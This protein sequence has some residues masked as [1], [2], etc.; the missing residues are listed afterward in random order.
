MSKFAAILAAAVLVALLG[1]TWLAVLLN[2]SDDRFADCRETAI[3]SGANGIGGAF[4]LVDSQ[5]QIV[6]DKEVITKPSLLYFGYTFCPDVCP[7]DSLRNA[8]AID[9]L[10]TQGYDANPIFISIDPNRDTPEVV[11]D[12]AARLHDK[13]IGLTG[14]AEQIEAVSTAYRTYHK[15]QDTDEEF[16]LIDHST[17]SYLVL[18]EH[19]FVEFFR[20]NISA[21]DVARRMACFI[22]LS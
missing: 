11:G 4:E 7:I 16:Y 13:M 5:G 1:G 8:D 22:D 17:F 12:F 2:R 20:R 14:T 21:E 15:A 9:L 6:S 19:G 18:P 10:A 3:A